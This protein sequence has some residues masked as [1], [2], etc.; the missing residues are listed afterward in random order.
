V[1]RTGLGIVEPLDVLNARLVREKGIKRVMRLGIPMGLVIV[2]NLSG[3]GRCEPVAFGD[4]HPHFP[5]S[6]CISGGRSRSEKAGMKSIHTV[7]TG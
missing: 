1:A 6:E 5:R 3:G 2:G 4:E 7:E